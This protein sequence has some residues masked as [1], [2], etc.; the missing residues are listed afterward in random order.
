VKG[1]AISLKVARDAAVK[2]W[3]RAP[4]ERCGTWPKLGA[5]IDESKADV[6]PEANDEWQTQHRTMQADG[7]AELR[8][9]L[10]NATPDPIST[11][12]GRCASV[13]P[14]AAPLDARSQTMP[15][16]SDRRVQAS[17]PMTDLISQRK[18]LLMM[19]REC[20]NSV[21]QRL[22]DRCPS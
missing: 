3:R 14:A 8:S 10:I 22:I 20:S 7:M 17:R 4:A 5:F 2:G 19:Q 18:S 1:T 13:V 12:A 6:L 11:L 15:G 9:P 16:G 21:S